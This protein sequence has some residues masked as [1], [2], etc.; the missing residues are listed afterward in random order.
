MKFPSNPL[1]AL[2]SQL[3]ELNE[4]LGKARNEYLS[5]EAIRDYKRAFII[6]AASGKSNA[7]KT[8]NAHATEEWLE[9][10]QKLAR[11]KAVYEFQK[12]KFSVM[13]K[14]YMTQYLQF[15]LDGSLIKKE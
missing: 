11:A 8:I 10:H 9:L 5:L 6:K 4:R 3:N 7:E 2:T 15:K 14:E 12:L 1:E 13:E